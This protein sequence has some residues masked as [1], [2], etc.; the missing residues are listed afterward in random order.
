MSDTETSRIPRSS[1]SIDAW[2]VFMTAPILAVVGV[3]YWFILPVIQSLIIPNAPG[4]ENG[5]WVVRPI[6]AFHFGAMAV[7]SAATLPV[8]LQLLRKACGS[9][10]A[11][12][13]A[14]YDPLHGRPLIRG[15]LFFKAF[16]LFAV[17][18][19]ALVFY[20]FSWKMIGPDG[21][22]EHLP[23]TTRKHSFQDI[24]SLETI[25]D[26]ERSESIRQ[27]GP[28]YSIKFKNGPPITLSEDNEACTHDELLAMTTYIADRSGLKWERKSDAQKRI[29]PHPKVIWETRHDNGAREH[30]P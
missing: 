20:L 27:D 8:V 24:V 10:D 29:D 14:Q 15:L 19:S 7:M 6:L 4:G 2:R 28:W 17:Y 23:W 16:L 9:K 22:E 18:A 1:S 13:G 26:G 3:C 30:E 11:A 5:P 12:L 21:I 25:P